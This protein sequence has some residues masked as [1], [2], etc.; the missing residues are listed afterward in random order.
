VVVACLALEAEAVMPVIHDLHAQADRLRGDAEG[1]RQVATLT[2]SE[3]TQFGQMRSAELAPA[4]F[5]LLRGS[6][7]T[8]V[9]PEGDNANWRVRGEVYSDLPYAETMEDGRRAGKRPPPRPP[10]PFPW[11]K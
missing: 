7:K 6:I 3:M 2:A 9:T 10:T 4:N 8:A 5:G 1:W 11:L